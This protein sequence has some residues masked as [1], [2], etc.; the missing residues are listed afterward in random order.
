[1]FMYN[2]LF[3][4]NGSERFAFLEGHNQLGLLML[5]LNQFTS[6]YVFFFY[7]VNQESNEN[8]GLFIN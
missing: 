7:L 3:F 2:T 4:F 6:Q 5:E 8:N 1:M